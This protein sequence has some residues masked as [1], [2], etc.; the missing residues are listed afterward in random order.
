MRLTCGSGRSANWRTHRCH[1]G[2]SRDFDQGLFIDDGRSAK[3]GTCDRDL[4]LARELPDQGAGGVGKKGQPLGQI[5]PRGEFGIRNKI[6]QNAVKQVDVIRPESCGA[7]REQ[8]GDPSGSLGAA[9]GIA[10]SD[11]FVELGDQRPG[12]RHQTH[13]NP[14]QPQAVCEFSGK[15]GRLGE[16]RVRFELRPNEPQNHSL[17]RRGP[18][19]IAQKPLY[20]R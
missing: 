5:G 8:L 17:G 3:Q 10:M 6:N 1:S 7:L 4:V 16:G 9:P 18:C 19:R 2:A 15:I 13:S 20:Q 11:D 14:Q 12:N